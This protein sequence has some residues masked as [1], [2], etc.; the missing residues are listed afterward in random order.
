MSG[1]HF[2]YEQYK[3]GY[4]ADS[5]EETILS[6]D[7][8]EKDECGYDLSR[9]YSPETILKFREAVATLRKAQRMAH[10]IDWLESG[11]DGEDT[12]NRRW[13]EEIDIE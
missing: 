1:G 11:D 10:R 7:S 2:Q 3:I 12:F 5:I 9:H 4:I 8:E 6:N 13:R